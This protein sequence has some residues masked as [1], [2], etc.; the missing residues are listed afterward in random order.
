MHLLIYL[1]SYSIL[2]QN[3]IFKSQTLIGK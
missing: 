1:L 3:R 2:L